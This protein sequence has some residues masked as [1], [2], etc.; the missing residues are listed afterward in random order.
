L[1]GFVALAGVSLVILVFRA[2]P[3]A[4]PGRDA[5]SRAAA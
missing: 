1:T 5:G 2:R 4:R 3:F